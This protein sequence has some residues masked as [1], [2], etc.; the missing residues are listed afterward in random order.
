MDHSVGGS[1]SIAT[2]DA[3]GTIGDQRDPLTELPFPL[4][5]AV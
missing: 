5:R 1:H 4:R 3:S 2:V